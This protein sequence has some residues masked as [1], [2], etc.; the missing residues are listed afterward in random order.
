VRVQAVHTHARSMKKWYHLV[1]FLVACS[2]GSGIAAL[3]K[4]RRA[5]SGAGASAAAFRTMSPEQAAAALKKEIAAAGQES[6]TALRE[7]LAGMFKLLGIDASWATALSANSA[8]GFPALMEKLSSVNTGQRPLLE[9]MLLDRWAQLDPEGAATFFKAKADANPQNQLADDGLANFIRQWG[10]IDFEKAAAKASEFG[11]KTM[12]RTFRE[13]AK[14]DPAGFLAWAKNHPEINPFSIFL[15]TNTDN[16]Q[17]VANMAELD[18][19]RVL[20]W[21]REAPV[22]KW[23]SVLGPTLAGKLAQ[24]NPDEAI[25]WAKALGDRTATTAALAGVAKVLADTDPARALGLLKEMG[26]STDSALLGTYRELI[27]KLGLNNPDSAVAVVAELPSGRLRDQMLAEVM[28]KLM[29]SDPQKAFALADK[30]GPAGQMNVGMSSSFAP[31]TPDEA[32]Q[33]L[34]LA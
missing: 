23:R 13:K 12:R 5:A 16:A 22:E 32:R 9:L 10:V 28:G 34:D 4:S 21:A 18:L 30:L 15:S 7:R 19:E 24:R 25:E 17:A 14:L 11:D 2:L 26:G 27:E 1:L 3:T 31:Q 33:L 29:T 20:A 8:A 6:G